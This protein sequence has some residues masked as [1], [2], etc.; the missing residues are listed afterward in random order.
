MQDKISNTDI[1]KGVRKDTQL[2]SGSDSDDEDTLYPNC[3]S[4]YRGPS[5]TLNVLTHSN[6]IKRRHEEDMNE[7]EQIK[8][9]V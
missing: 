3:H 5:N 1:D 9:G 7:A 4:L 8:V 6:T 2:N